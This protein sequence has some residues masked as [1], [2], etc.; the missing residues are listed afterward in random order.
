M[1]MKSECYSCKHMRTVPGDC[2][3]QCVK[4]DRRMTGEPHGIIQGWFY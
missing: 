3:I 4:P 1:D 2:H